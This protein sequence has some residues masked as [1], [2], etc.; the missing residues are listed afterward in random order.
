MGT[1]ACCWQKAPCQRTSPGDHYS[2]GFH[3]AFFF[4]FSFLFRKNN[5]TVV[6]DIE[7]ITVTYVPL[8]AAGRQRWTYCAC[9]WVTVP[10]KRCAPLA[11][12]RTNSNTSHYDDQMVYAS[13]NLHGEGASL[14]NVAQAHRGWR[15][16]RGKGL[17]R[18]WAGGWGPGPSP[19]CIRLESGWH[20]GP[21]VS[22]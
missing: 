19:S 20:S 4:F 16:R 15:P 10:E 9:A 6:Q 14:S 22:I 2:T 8:A 11:S 12:S 7:D 13:I 21:M 3:H 17:W 5:N 18:S 1:L